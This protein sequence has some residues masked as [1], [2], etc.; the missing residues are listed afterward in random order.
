MQ[1]KETGLFKR[2]KEWNSLLVFVITLGVVFSGAGVY[3]YAKPAKLDAR[4]GANEKAIKGI[5][6]DHE[7]F[8]DRI[9]RKL[10]RIL[11]FVAGG[12]NQ[13]DNQTDNLTKN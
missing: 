5:K 6:V 7:K 9:D 4:V 13:T 2:I 12:K 8:A 10:E 11:F 1:G 3:F